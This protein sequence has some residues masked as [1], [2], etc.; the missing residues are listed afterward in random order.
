MYIQS[1]SR[2]CPATWRM[3]YLQYISVA[4]SRLMYVEQRDTTGQSPF[5]LGLLVLTQIV[6]LTQKNDNRRRK[7]DTKLPPG[8]SGRLYRR[9]LNVYCAIIYVNVR[10]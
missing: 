4:E 2:L 9:T 8:C 6:K 10:K 1:V 7:H 5:S 3:K